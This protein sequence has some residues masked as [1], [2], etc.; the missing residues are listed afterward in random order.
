M[1]E[2]SSSSSSIPPDLNAILEAQ[3]I[4]I[5]T[6]VNSQIQGVQS[7]LLKAQTD[8]ASQIASEVQP[9]ATSLRRKATSNSSTLI[10]K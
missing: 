7:Y 2:K 5:L 6:A 3:K 8:L 9:E 4:A 1:G 10:E